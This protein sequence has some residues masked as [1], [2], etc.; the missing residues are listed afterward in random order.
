MRLC[1]NSARRTPLKLSADGGG[2][3]I[4]GINEPLVEVWI[5]QVAGHLV[6]DRGHVA[7]K[8]TGNTGMM[9]TDRN[10]RLALRFEATVGDCSLGRPPPQ[11]E[12]AEALVFERGPAKVELLHAALGEKTNRLPHHKI[13]PSQT[14]FRLIRGTELIDRFVTPNKE[15]R[16]RHRGRAASGEN[17]ESQPGL[18]DLLVN[19]GKKSARLRWNTVAFS[20]EDVQRDELLQRL[21]SALNVY[22]ETAGLALPNR[23]ANGATEPGKEPFGSGPQIKRMTIKCPR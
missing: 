10:A 1:L 5:K 18:D 15:D 2:W 11:L 12:T 20:G 17:D 6:C 9:G 23:A 3:A 21:R 22:G 19:L 8:A 13:V 4:S 16:G 7:E 14:L